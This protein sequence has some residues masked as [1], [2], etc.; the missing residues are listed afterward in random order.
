MKHMTVQIKYGP[1]EHNY[2]FFVSLYKIRNLHSKEM[3]RLCPIP[4]VNVIS[5]ERRRTVSTKRVSQLGSLHSLYIGL[6]RIV[7]D[8]RKKKY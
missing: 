8:S 6:F 1:R 2:L 3:Y 4:T 5:F 7:L